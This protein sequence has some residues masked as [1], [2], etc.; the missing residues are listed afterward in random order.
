MDTSEYNNLKCYKND[1]KTTLDDPVDDSGFSLKDYIHPEESFSHSSLDMVKSSADKDDPLRDT[2]AEVYGPQTKCQ[3]VEFTDP[4][5]VASGDV[6]PV[7]SSPS[8][9]PPKPL[10]TDSHMPTVPNPFTDNL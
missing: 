4:L 6:D 10:S 9:L 5:A 2:I 7:L 1:G 3:H 8:P